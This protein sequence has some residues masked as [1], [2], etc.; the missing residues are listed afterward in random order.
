MRR[1]AITGKSRWLCDDHRG[2][3]VGGLVDRNTDL[4]QCIWP[5]S[6]IRPFQLATIVDDQKAAAG[7]GLDDH[8]GP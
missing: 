4:H 8:G 2:D 3:E 1:R 6:S 5:I 7:L